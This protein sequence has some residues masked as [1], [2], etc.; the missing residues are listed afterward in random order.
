MNKILTAHGMKNRTEL[1]VSLSE[2]NN[3]PRETITP[4]EV[5]FQHL[6]H[7]YKSLKDEKPPNKHI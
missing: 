3:K 5:I 2:G 1:D 4:Q 7:F 6:L